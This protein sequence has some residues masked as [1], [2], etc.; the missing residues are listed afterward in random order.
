MTNLLQ[1]IARAIAQ[2]GDPVLLGVVWRS[3]LLSAL[4]FVAL[5]AGAVG[6]VHHLLDWQGWWRW[7]AD[8]L[9]GLGTALLALWLFLP[10][11][12]VLGALYIERVARAV[13]RRYYPA[14][15]PAHGE[16]LAIQ[17]WD[18]IALGGRILLLNVVAL[19]LALLL[20]GI[21]LLLAWAI[22]SFAIGRGLFVAVAMRRMSR[23]EAEAVYRRRR[24]AVLVQGGLLA[25]ASYVPLLNL[26]LPVVGTAAMVHVLDD[27]L[28]AGR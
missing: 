7:L 1:P 13:E 24:P 8:L 21:G 3:V 19:V 26:L 17:F 12:G 16:S 15:P 5:F 20:P 2:L 28:A 22:A 25:L 18:G 4:C 23:P 10:V 6:I 11:A 27:A 14:L 9:S